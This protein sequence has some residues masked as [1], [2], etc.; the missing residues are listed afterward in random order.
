[1]GLVVDEIVDIVEERLDIEVASERAG[2][3]GYAVVK[4][5][6]TEIDRR[7]PLSCRSR[8][9]TGCSARDAAARR[10]AS[11]R[12]PGRRLGVLPR[13]AR[14]ADQG[15]RLSWSSRSAP[16]R[17]RW[18]R[19]SP[20]RSTS[21]SPTSKCRAWTALRSRRRCAPI[22][23]PRRCR[24]SRCPPWS[25]PT[26]IERGRAAGF[27]D[28]VA[29]FDRAGLIAAIKEQSAELARAA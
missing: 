23:R 14:A 11:R 12:A 20:A 3:L 1:M 17:R 21:S 15:R 29:K 5:H 26:A 28:F 16:A 10:G 8:S 2:V 25:R 9:T 27:H 4:G 24:S 22:R 7:R 6:A 19:R 18:R 13:H